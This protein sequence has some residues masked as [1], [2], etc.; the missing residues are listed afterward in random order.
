MGIM[1]N[2]GDPYFRMKHHMN[3]EVTTCPRCNQ[4]THSGERYCTRCGEA[5]PKPGRWPTWGADTPDVEP[6][7]DYE[8][9]VEIERV[10]SLWAAPGEPDFVPL[11]VEP[12]PEQ[13]PW[14]GPRLAKLLVPLGLVALIVLWIVAER[15]IV[16]RDSWPHWDT[17]WYAAGGLTLL[18]SGILATLL[19]MQARA[20]GGWVQA[21]TWLFS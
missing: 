12:L 13:R 21:L 8:D 15:M 18:S 16:S 14:L 5:L 19:W 7:E 10:D 3:A 1:A 11:P 9:V 6:E 17:V 2:E 20:R 4:E